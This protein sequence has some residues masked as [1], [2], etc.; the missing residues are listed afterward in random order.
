MDSTTQYGMHSRE[1][2]SLLVSDQ[3]KTRLRRHGAEALTTVELLALVLDGTGNGAATLD[4]VAALLHS[5]AGSLRKLRT[6]PPGAF[7]GMDGI[8]EAGAAA[9]HA[10]CEIARRYASETCPEGKELTKASDIYEYY[11]PRLEDL[12]VEE[13]HV[14]ILDAR[15]RLDH[16]RLVSR[17]LLNSAPVHPREVFRDAIAENA[18]AVILVHNHP[19]GD[20]TPSQQDRMITSQLCSAGKVLGIEVL[21]HVIVGRRR[22]MSFA[23]EGILI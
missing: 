4:A 16:D 18:C 1:Q 7:R 15:Y 10:V 9:I 11:G 21:D 12:T 2:Q 5:T 20:P 22:F 3:P 23:E 13:F 17:G 14:G 6:R 19:S 8:G